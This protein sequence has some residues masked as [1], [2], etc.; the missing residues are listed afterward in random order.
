[1]NANIG[2]SK[3]MGFIGTWML[4]L[5]LFGSSGA[6]A[7]MLRGQMQY[8]AKCAVC[9][10]AGATVSRAPIRETLLEFTPERVLEAITSGV[11]KSQ[12]EGLTDEQK[13]A[14]A[15]YVALRPLGSSAKGDASAFKN[16]CSATTPI[17]EVSGGATWNGWSPDHS[18]ARFQSSSAAGLTA[19]QIP[20]LKLKWAF[21]FPGATSVYAQPVVVDGHLFTSSDAGYVY[22]LAAETGCI[23]WS[24][25]ASAGVRTPIIIGS[26]PIRGMA[27]ARHIAYFGDV[28]A[29]VYA[30][31]ADTGRLLWKT[32]V[33]RH[34]QARITGGIV[35]EGN[36]LLVPVSSL[37]ELSG[38]D[39]HYECCTFRGSIVALEASSGNQIWKTYTIQEE[40]EP[41]KK[42]A[43]GVQL[44]GPAGGAVWNTPT[45]DP[46]R[47]ELYFGT[48]NAYTSP[49]APTTDSVM[50]L[51]LRTGRILWW[52]QVV[53]QDAWVIGCGRDDRAR[54]D[55]CPDRNSQNSTY[56]DVDM[57]A[58]P[59]LHHLPD[60]R[61]ILITTG[62]AGLV[63]ALDPAHE[64]RVVWTADL[65]KMPIQSP[66]EPGQGENQPGVAFG[67][68]AD[69]RAAYFPL[70]RHEGGITAINLASGKE[71]WHT[72]APKPNCN[73]ERGCNAEQQSAA[74]VI[75]GA[76]FSGAR[77]GMLHAYSTR[78]GKPLWEFNT[79][80]SFQ[81]VNGVVAK[82]GGLGGPGVTVAG[83]MVFSN[84]GYGVL[85]GTPGNVLLAFAVE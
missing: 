18:N 45:I 21:G 56:F 26:G 25:S 1:M 48:G 10:S 5:V 53:N 64:G 19:E 12:A 20:R 49:A 63:N 76:V 80:Q 62:E 38:N 85:Q 78:D 35:L 60:G 46:E 6:R 43:S 36:R 70:E 42:S 34:S 71:L 58:S 39:S 14:V 28:R 79:K 16:Q 52:Y 72:L 2:R 15:E 77:D 55:H 23:Y 9:H 11:M 4:V 47:G 75:S 68:A 27:T 8:E 44:W 84:S 57:A 61:R 81:T 37:E 51:D 54:T 65:G 3:R 33:E 74:T 22:S 67:G 73:G 24:F 13:R 17:G 7:Q 31:D 66:R 59:I 30:V 41:T 69:E 29:N 50:A 40:P 32:Q 82:G 83:G